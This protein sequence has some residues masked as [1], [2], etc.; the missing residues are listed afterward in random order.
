MACG[1][2][3]ERQQWI[4]EYIGRFAPGSRVHQAALARAEQMRARMQAAED[5]SETKVQESSTLGAHER[6]QEAQ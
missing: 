6:Q 2:C 3:A 4:A 1:A 5:R